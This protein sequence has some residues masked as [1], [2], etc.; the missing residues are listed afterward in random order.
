M[1]ENVSTPFLF[2]FSALTNIRMMRLVHD[3]NV[4]ERRAGIVWKNLKVCGSGS[5]INLQ[6]NV[7]SLLLAPLR[8]GEFFHKGAE[9]TI[10]NE[11]DGV[12]KS[13]EML[14][15]LGRPGS[16]CSTLLKTLMGEL[17]GL[18]MKAQ[19][20]IHYNGMPRRDPHPKPANFIRYYPEANAQAISRRD[21]VQSRSRQTLP[22]SY[23]RRD[24]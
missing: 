14:V 23:G 1:D 20:E 16:G 7:G 8:F 4:V 24:T 11:F 17:H 13:G 3:N 21:C 18:D 22:P 2:I 9:K 12:L 5:A 19:S 6:K 15:V 10:L